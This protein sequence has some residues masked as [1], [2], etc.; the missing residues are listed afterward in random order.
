MSNNRDAKKTICNSVL[1]CLSGSKREEELF[2]LID[3][4]QKEQVLLPENFTDKL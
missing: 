3:I 2:G 1:P 4:L